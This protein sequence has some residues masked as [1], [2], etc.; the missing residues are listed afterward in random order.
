MK[1]ITKKII[2]SCLILSFMFVMMSVPTF[3][4]ETESPHEILD[5]GIA[6]LEQEY[7]VTIKK[8]PTTKAS[9][10]LSISEV[11]NSLQGLESALSEGRQAR[12]DNQTD[13]ENYMN[14]LRASGRLD[15]NS[16]DNTISPK[17]LKTR[18]F[19]KA[20]GSLVPNG[21]TI[22]CSMTG[23]TIL[24]S[25]GNTIWGQLNSHYSRRSSG[26]GTNWVETD[27]SVQRMDGGR[28]YNC[29]YIGTLE[30]PYKNAGII[31]YYVYSEG[32]RIWFEAYAMN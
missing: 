9:S 21:T 29:S 15:D 17:A 4:A 32:W 11:N 5:S 28:T 2:S 26:Y 12:I 20:I 7:D 31:Q 6:Q 27:F 3:A 16:I 25:F 19:Y 23:S 14:Q 1:R 10:A 22:L 30:E 13:Y 18:V 8:A 24:D